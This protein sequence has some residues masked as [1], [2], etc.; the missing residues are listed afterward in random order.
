MITT[1]ID[2]IQQTAQTLLRWLDTPFF[3]HSMLLLSSAKQSEYL[4]A[5]CFR[6][7]ANRMLVSLQS[8]LA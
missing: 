8:Q 1:A 4:N 2:S 6:N 5:V 7:D 3:T